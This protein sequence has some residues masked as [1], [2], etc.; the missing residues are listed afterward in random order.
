[1]WQFVEAVVTNHAPPPPNFISLLFV[2]TNTEIDV[3]RSILS[4]LPN[5]YTQE[6]VE[7]EASKIAQD[8]E[9]NFL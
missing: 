4:Y 5:M 6:D 7:A 1:M 8:L 9:N 3:S 2:F